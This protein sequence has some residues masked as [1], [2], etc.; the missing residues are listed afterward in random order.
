MVS[1]NDLDKINELNNELKELRQNLKYSENLVEL[2][3][4]ISPYCDG[5]PIYLMSGDPEL[6]TIEEACKS[7]LN[8]KIQKILSELKTLGLDT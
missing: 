8:K 5:D 7:L 2:E 3:I 6:R 4:N 1:L